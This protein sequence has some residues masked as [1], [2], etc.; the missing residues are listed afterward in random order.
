VLKILGGVIRV[1]NEHYLRYDSWYLNNL[2]FSLSEKLC[3]KV[4][5]PYGV[6]LDIDMGTGFITAGLSRTMIG[7][8]PAEKPLKIARERG[9]LPVYAYGN[10]LPFRDNALDTVLVNVTLSFVENPLLFSS[11]RVGFAR[12][13][14]S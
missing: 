11:K 13:V 1:F 3:I 6:V 5:A 12:E 9:F 14:G 4:L 10:E 2:N 7:L 8:D